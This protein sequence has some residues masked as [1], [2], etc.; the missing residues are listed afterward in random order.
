MKTILTRLKTLINDNNNSGGTLEYVKSFEVVHPELDLTVHSVSAFPRIVFVPISTVES[1]VGSQ[2]KQAVNTVIAYLML[3]Y[4]TREANIIGDA[5]RPGGQGKGILDFVADYLSVVRGHRLAVDDNIYL[6]KPL[7]ILNVEYIRED[8]SES[9]HLLVAAVTM[10][11]SRLFTQ[12]TL[13]GN[14]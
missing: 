3:R 14:V 10:E 2:R 4:H 11:C 7:D 1:W 6:D 8:I 9:A 13:P 5:T 12:Q